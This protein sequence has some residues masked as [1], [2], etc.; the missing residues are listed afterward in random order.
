[1]ISNELTQIHRKTDYLEK[2]IEK[3]IYIYLFYVA[4]TRRIGTNKRIHSYKA[5]SYIQ[6]KLEF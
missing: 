6:Q 5:M 1:M 4:M 2:I 3:L